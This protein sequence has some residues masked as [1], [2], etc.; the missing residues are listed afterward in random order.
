MQTQDITL[1]LDET[2]QFDIGGAYFEIIEGAGALDVNFT[3]SD[4]S[5]GGDLEMLG[6]LPGYYV[7]GPFSRFELRNRHTQPQTVRVMYGRGVGGSRRVQGAVATVDG[8]KINTIAG[9]TFMANV[10]VS[11]VAAQYP[12]LQLWVPPGTVGKVHLKAFSVSSQDAGL[13][14]VRSAAAA[15]LTFEGSLAS[16]LI[17][18][19]A[20]PTL[21]LR[22]ENNVAVLGTA[23]MAAFR[24]EANGTHRFILEE[25]IVIPEGF[26]VNFV[27]LTVNTALQVTVELLIE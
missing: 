17:G 11:P 22:R 2:K 21:Q 23:G 3:N 16:K 26:G 27:H 8:G 4:G 1:A 12:H 14:N 6:A 20:H 10:S 13:I 19:A 5:R 9:K 15:L 18:S 25:P 7:V 24:V